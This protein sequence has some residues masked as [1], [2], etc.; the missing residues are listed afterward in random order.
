VCEKPR[1]KCAECPNRRFLPVTDQV[2]RQHLSGHDEF[3]REFVIGVYPL[4]PDETCFLLAVDLDGNT[5]EKDAGAFLETCRR[6]ALPV[7][8]ERS[9]RAKADIFGFSLRKQSPRLWREI[10]GRIS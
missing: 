2:I 3:G 10:L 7:A 4:L 9:D 1:I 5:W 6:L 8:L